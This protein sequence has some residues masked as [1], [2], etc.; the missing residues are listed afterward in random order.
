MKVIAKGIC[1]VNNFLSDKTGEIIGTPNGFGHY[2]IQ[3]EATDEKGIAYEVFFMTTHGGA[4]SASPEFAVRQSDGRHDLLFADKDLII[5]KRYTQLE[6]ENEEK[7]IAQLENRG[8]LTLAEKNELLAAKAETGE[9]FSSALVETKTPKFTREMC[10]AFQ[11]GAE[12]GTYSIHFP[13]SRQCPRISIPELMAG[14]ER[15]SASLERSMRDIEKGRGF[16][17][18]EKREAVEDAQK[19]ACLPNA[20]RRISDAEMAAVFYENEKS[21][22]YDYFRG[23]EKL[24]PEA[25]IRESFVKEYLKSG[26]KEITAQTAAGTKTGSEIEHIRGRIQYEIFCQERPELEHAFDGPGSEMNITRIAKAIE[27][28]SAQKNEYGVCSYR[29]TAGDVLKVASGEWA[30]EIRYDREMKTLFI[31][32]REAHAEGPGKKDEAEKP[33]EAP[34]EKDDG[35]DEDPAD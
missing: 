16:D 15:A 28:T 22:N 9:D 23:M 14:L 30:P 34:A 10:A 19:K 24:I 4:Y 13:G 5:R 20:P 29:T 1:R 3:F 18:N 17:S 26:E 2:G 11:V 8:D 21:E 6:K 33:A 27:D 25:E 12:K 31:L 35:W 7:R 32:D